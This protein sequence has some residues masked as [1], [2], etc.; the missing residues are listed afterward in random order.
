MRQPF[1]VLQEQLV[2]ELIDHGDWISGLSLCAN[3]FNQKFDYKT[4]HAIN[5]NIQEVYIN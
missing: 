4:I 3:I 2:L 1:N 5:F